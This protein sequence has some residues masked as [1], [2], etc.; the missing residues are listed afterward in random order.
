MVTLLGY[1]FVVETGSSQVEIPTNTERLEIKHRDR[2][3]FE[4]VVTCAKLDITP[5]STILN[6]EKLRV[7][8]ISVRGIF[9]SD[10]VPKNSFTK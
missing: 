5:K 6:L 10:S 3:N 8:K 9:V 7:H 4:K 1:P 2:V